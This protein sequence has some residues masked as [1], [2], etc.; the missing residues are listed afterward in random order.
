[1]VVDSPPGSTSMSTPSRSAGVRTSTG[2]APRLDKARQCSR[3]RALQGQN[4]DPA[5][6]RRPRG[7]VS[8]RSVH[9]AAPFP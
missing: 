9:L 1:M 3:N 2:M 4:P 6:R 8:V 7:A 5:R